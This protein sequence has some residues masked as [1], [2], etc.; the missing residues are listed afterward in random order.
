VPPVA[1]AQVP[2]DAVAVAI[3]DIQQLGRCG[4]LPAPAACRRAR[5][6][7][8]PQPQTPHMPAR[9]HCRHAVACLPSSLGAGA[10]LQDMPSFEN[11]ASA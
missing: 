6:W 1:G 8:L 5:R 9:L 3:A 4:R 11:T 10:A 7:A 2:E